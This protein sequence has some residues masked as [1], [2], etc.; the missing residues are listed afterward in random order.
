[1]EESQN[2]GIPPI[3][4]HFFLCLPRFLFEALT[5]ARGPGAGEPGGKL[6]S[7]NVKFVA[8]EGREFQKQ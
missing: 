5:A 7:C 8:P 6:E 2:G 4:F 1:M 3:I